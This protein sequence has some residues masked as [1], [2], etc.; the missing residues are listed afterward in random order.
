[1]EEWWGEQRTLVSIATRALLA[2]ALLRLS[3]VA[4]LRAILAGLVV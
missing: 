4:S 3:A 2:V 1:M